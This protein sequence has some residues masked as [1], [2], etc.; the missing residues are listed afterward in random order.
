[1]SFCSHACPSSPDVL[2]VAFLVVVMFAI[3]HFYVLTRSLL[4]LYEIAD[5][6]LELRTRPVATELSTA[7][8]L[9]QE[10][11]Y[12]PWCHESPKWTN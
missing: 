1:M 6:C 5:G 7:V 11:F 8:W 2:A 4:T 12:E 9:T 3:S 10:L